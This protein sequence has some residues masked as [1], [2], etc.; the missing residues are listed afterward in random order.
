M[1]DT[2]SLPAFT[3][4]VLLNKNLNG[5]LKMDIKYQET[6]NLGEIWR[7]V[8]RFE[9]VYEVSNHGNVRSLD[10]T[11]RKSN[12]VCHIN[13]KVISPAL[14]NGYHRLSLNNKTFRSNMFVHR[15]VALAFLDNPNRLPIINHKN[16]IRTDNRVQNLEWSTVLDNNRHALNTG[17]KQRQQTEYRK[18]VAVI[19]IGTREEVICNS[20]NEAAELIGEKTPGSISSF[21]RGGRKHV[22][23]FIFRYVDDLHLKGQVSLYDSIISACIDARSKV[24]QELS[25][26][27]KEQ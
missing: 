26:L 11:V 15:I 23:G 3:A 25:R 13:G 9:G 24:L 10:R 12:A 27:K 20:L 6:E 21:F 17:L 5:H 18:R 2:G 7:P 8:A 14:V 4:T 22:K 16:G 19:N 1:S